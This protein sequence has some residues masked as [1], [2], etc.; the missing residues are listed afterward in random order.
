MKLERIELTDDN[1]AEMIEVTFI[2][3]CFQLATGYVDMLKL[4][5]ASTSAAYERK[6]AL[7]TLIKSVNDYPANTAGRDLL[8]D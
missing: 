6:I 3:A 1:I 5:L 4:F 2:K 7:P 8:C